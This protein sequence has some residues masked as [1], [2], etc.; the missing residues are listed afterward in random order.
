[1]GAEE[2]REGGGGRADAGDSLKRGDSYTGFSTSSKSSWEE[3]YPLEGGGG[4]WLLILKCGLSPP[5]PKSGFVFRP[6]PAGAGGK[7]GMSSSDGGGGREK[8]P[9]GGS[10]LRVVS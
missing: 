3:E 4:R 2:T 9:G 6:N 1:M 7:E 10:R 8:W 5:D